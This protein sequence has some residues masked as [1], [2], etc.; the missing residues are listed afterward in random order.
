MF[1]TFQEELEEEPCIYGVKRAVSTW[2][3]IKINWIHAWQIIKD[4]W[5]T[6]NW[7]DKIK[8]WFMPTGWRPDDVKE[9][10]PVNYTEDPYTQIKYNPH[11]SKSVHIWSWFQ[12]ILSTLLLTHMLIYIS[13]IGF[14]MLFLYGGFLFLM[15]YSFS[16]LMDK[17]KVAPW[18]EAIK[19]IFGLGIIYYTGCWFNLDELVPG[20]TI[21]IAFYLVISIAVVYY[22]TRT[23]II[24]K[25][26]VFART[27]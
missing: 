27:D 13:K 21:F 4:S 9:K 2:N 6:K 18:M 10:Y 19:S 23:E 5:R 1:G 8:V 17:E 15:I 25:N 20:G 12:Y 7:I 11:V 24:V 26:H 22:F 16:S 14:P 3:P